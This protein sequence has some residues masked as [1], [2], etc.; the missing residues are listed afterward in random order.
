MPVSEAEQD[1]RP[2]A[3]PQHPPSAR[4]GSSW[5]WLNATLLVVVLGLVAA[6]VLL[7]VKGPVVTP[8]QSQA[9][10]L[11]RQYVQVTKAARAE[12]LAFLSVDYQNMDPLIAKVLAGATGSFKDQ[13]DKAKVNIKASAQSS[14]AK[15]TSSIKA[16]GLG[17]VQPDS[18]VVFVAVDSQVT[19]RL[20]KGVA[21]PR[22]YRLQLSMKRVSGR[23]LTSDLQ[24]VG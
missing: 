6:T 12:T 17:E 2:D 1:H 16:M 13:Y 15:T 21:Q 19:N 20:T 4:P 5:G 14:Q 7:W 24:F 8:G 10:A 23:W 11:S 9:E 22:Y 3:A 18:A